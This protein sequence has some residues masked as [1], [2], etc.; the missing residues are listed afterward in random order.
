MTEPRIVGRYVLHAAIAA[1]GTA[2]VH[3]GR[4]SASAGF[5]RTVAIKRMLPSLARDPEFVAMFIDEARLAARIRHA[6]VV[7][8]IDVV[9]VDQELLLVMDYVP[10]EALSR[11]INVCVER[12]ER[13]P[14]RIVLAIVCDLLHGLHAVH[15]ACDERGQPLGIVHRDVS[16][17]NVL[18][19]VD[20][21]SRVHD[22][23]T[24]K[25]K[26]RI[27]QT[28]DG[29]IKGKL[30]YMAP[31][32]VRGEV[33]DARCDV[34]AAGAVLWELLTLERLIQGH[35][36]EAMLQA[37]LERSVPSLRQAAPDTSCQLEDVIMRALSRDP[38]D[39]FPTVRDM[40]IAL[41]IAAPVARAREVG[42]WV[43]NL[44]K[45]TLAQ[46]ARTLSAIECAAE[47]TG[48]LPECA[49]R[50]HDDGSE[51]PTD[52]YDRPALRD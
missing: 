2:T 3:F 5:A 23:G 40:A 1:G 11:L 45:A 49:L 26:G 36:K 6:N 9:S 20:G 17:Q 50:N 15:Q 7:E 28:R 12:G 42:D 22:F 25:A 29:Q 48:S 38:S 46:N 51:L 14:E 41:E 37:I 47:V 31:E 10:G 32:Q 18:V 52:V 43:Q 34:Y 13:I 16:P 19:G 27:A 33:L 4:Y 44:A 21:T 24:A 30:A 39:R 35:S 8:I